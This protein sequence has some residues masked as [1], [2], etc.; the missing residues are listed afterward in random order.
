MK[1][2]ELLQKMTEVQQKIGASKPYICG[3]TSRDKYLNKLDRISDIDITTG[4]KTV[5]YLSQEFAIE[6][7][8]DYNIIRK[9]MSDGHSSIFIGN[10]K[11]DFSSNFIIEGIDGFL[12][13]M[14]IT[15]P[16]N[17]QR[18]LFSRD[19]TCNALLLSFDLKDVIDPTRRG[20]N[21][22]KEKKIKTCLSPEITLTSNKNR[23]IRAI[24]LASKLNFDVDKSIIDYVK[25]NPTS[26]KISSTKSLSEKLNDAFKWDAD[27]TSY[28]LTEMHL[29]N[30]IPIT[31]Q[32]YPYYKRHLK[33]T[34][35]NV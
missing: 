21:D 14:G 13:K 22:I 15:K 28:L 12:Q 9:N 24:Y 1:L 5:D 34:A 17:M 35:A 16:T 29:W 18:E 3:G 31:E 30:Y 10:I 19:F 26:I 6:L 27:R 23:V 4:D 8:K 7:K 20:F 25:R 32:V 2:R 33:G 11:I